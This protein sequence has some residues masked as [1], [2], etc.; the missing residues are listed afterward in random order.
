MAYIYEI[1]ARGLASIREKWSPR[2][3]LNGRPPLYKSDALPLSYTGWE[4]NLG[5]E[6][7]TIC[8]T[9][10]RSTAELN[11]QKGRFLSLN[12]NTLKAAEFTPGGLDKKSEA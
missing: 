6:P 7:R 5:F 8:L 11:P 10:K 12:K 9:G 1:Y 3:G 4:G 2:S